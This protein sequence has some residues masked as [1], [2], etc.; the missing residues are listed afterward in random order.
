ME[1]DSLARARGATFLGSGNQDFVII[2]SGVSLLGV[3]DTAR[4]LSHD[5]VISLDEFGARTHRAAGVGESPAPTRRRPFAF[6]RDV[7]SHYEVFAAQLMSNL[8]LELRS[9]FVTRE[10]VYRVGAAAIRGA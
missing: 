3:C 10:A 5:R 4:S 6:G 8:G 7:P 1:L 9:G 2:Q